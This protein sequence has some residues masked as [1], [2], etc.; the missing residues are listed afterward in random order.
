MDFDIEQRRQQEETLSKGAPDFTLRG[1]KFHMRKVIPHASLK[2][3]AGIRKGSSDDDVFSALENT[4]ISL[5]AS[6]DDRKRFAVL[7]RDTTS[8]FPVTMENLIDVQNWMIKEATGRP[9]T[10]P[11]SS[12]DSS[13]TNGT[14]ET[15]ASSPTPDE[16]SKI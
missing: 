8:E 9:P 11:E 7:L 12:S 5:L 4:I 13:S 6:D 2:A 16:A 3:I 10:P 1:Q 15:E 14:S